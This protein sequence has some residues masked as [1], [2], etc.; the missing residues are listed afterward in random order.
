MKL[1]TRDIIHK[2]PT[3]KLSMITCYDYSFARILDNRV[4]MILIGDS[5]GHVI[6]GYDRTAHVRMDDI[7]THLAAVRRGAPNTFI[8]ADL[9][10]GTYSTESDALANARHLMDIGADAVRF[11]ILISSPAGNDL[12]W[13]KASNE[14]G[15]NFINKIW[16]ALKLI[17]LWKQREIRFMDVDAD[18]FA[19]QNWPNYWFAARLQQARTEIDQMFRQFRLSE[20]LKA[21]YSL[22]WDDYCSWYLEWIKPAPE[23]AMNGHHLSEAIRFFEELM[24]MLHPFMPFITEEVYQHLRER[25]AGDDLCIARLTE[26]DLLFFEGTPQDAAAYLQ[27][28]ELLKSA[29]SGIRDARN[30]AQLRP[31]DMVQL[32]CQPDVTGSY[33][34]IAPLL[35]R[36]VNAEGFAITGQPA[37]GAI[38]QV[39]GK[40]RFFIV[41]HT[42]ADTSHQAAELAK[43]LEYLRGFL[44]SVNKKLENEKFVQNAKAEVV[45]IERKKQADAL[46]KIKAIEESLAS[47]AKQ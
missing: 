5:M 40:D 24:E 8:I 20:A 15:R 28:G 21:I 2:K 38:T 12:L 37:P 1:T 19:K 27:E 35:C 9:P 41:T 32:L 43:E 42:Q 29:I 23:E 4:D 3:N 31:R 11:G 39:V 44:Q 34:T 16:N 14:Q 10:A 6:L 47:I 25:A 26:N 33:D 30:K 22:I 45:A 36:Q 18:T 13:D 17:Q 7:S 46:D